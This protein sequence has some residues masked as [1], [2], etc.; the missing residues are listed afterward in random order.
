M[1]EIY[2]ALQQK[3]HR[4]LIVIAEACNKIAP[5]RND[6][7]SVSL[8]GYFDPFESEEIHFKELFSNSRGDF[9]MSSSSV[10]EYS[11]LV[12]GNPGFFTCSFRDTFSYFTSNEYTETATWENIFN[13]T[14]ELTTK[15]CKENGKTQN[16][17]W[18][19]GNNC[20]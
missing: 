15:L 13:Q 3:N 6:L 11:E 10:G 4:L 12:I 18:C 8:N 7:Y 19:A 5:S 16:P 2:K 20:Y 17:Q 1:I 9:L 14:K